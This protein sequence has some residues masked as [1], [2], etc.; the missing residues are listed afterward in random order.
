MSEVFEGYERQ[1]CE[2]SANLSSNQKK[3][4]IAEVKAGLED[5]DAMPSVKAA[6]LAKLREY[7]TD[8]NNL[9]TQVKRI[10]SPV[11]KFAARYVLL[12]PGTADSL[13]TSNN[14]RGRLLMTTESRKAMLETK[15]LHQQRESLLH[16]PNALHGVDESFSKSKVNKWIVGSIIGV[17]AVAILSILYLKIK[18]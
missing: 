4:I 11:A 9:K 14:Q 18:R 8:L 17:F 16:A 10:T 15:D 6:F 5:A 13:T 3:Q 2:L 1:Y 7:K 12:E